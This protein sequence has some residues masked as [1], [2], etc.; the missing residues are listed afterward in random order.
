[1]SDFLMTKL[2]TRYCYNFNSTSILIVAKY[3]IA[4]F[5]CSMVS[6]VEPPNT[7]LPFPYLYYYR[8]RTGK[9]GPYAAYYLHVQPGGQSLIG[10]Y[11]STFS[12]HKFPFHLNLP[13]LTGYIYV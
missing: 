3:A 6:R 11:L 1:M 5:F 10:M 7:I 12:L 13:K 8:S 4:S 9:K 2:P